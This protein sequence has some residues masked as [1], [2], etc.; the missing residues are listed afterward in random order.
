[1]MSLAAAAPKLNAQVIGNDVTFTR[2][3]TDSRNLRAGDLFVALRGERFDGHDFVGDVFA[4]GAAAAMVEQDYGARP[5]PLLVVANTRLGLGHLAQAW[6]KDLELKVVAITGSNGKTTV[7][8]M[9]AAILRAHCVQQ[10]GTAM[11]VLATE[12]NLNND[13]GVPLTLLRLSTAHRYAVIEM[14]MNHPGEI[15]Y[16]AKLAQPDAALVNNVQR[17]HLGMFANIDAV[18]DAKAEIFT[19]LRWDGVAVINADDPHA[20]LMRV[21]A[22]GMECLEFGLEKP[23]PI[24]ASFTL[25]EY[26]SRIELRT[27]RGTAQVQLPL[28]GRHNVC[29]ALAATAAATALHIEL[30]PIVAGLQAV[31][32]VKGRLVR[33]RGV[34]GSVVIDDTYNANPD[35]A[36]AALQVLAQLSGEKIFVLGDMGEVGAGGAEMHA[37]IGALARSSGINRLYALGELSRQAA[38]MFGDGAE[39]F[40]QVEQLLSALR[41]RLQAGS[42]VLVKGSRFMRMERVVEAIV[43]SEVK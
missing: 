32:S 25:M 7:K 38:A 19:G 28:P 24:S 42:N 30:P 5:G 4:A 11:Q 21:R 29:N 17:A 41:P 10:G 6:R 36:A 9:V 13:I 31:Q 8:E 40:D 26:G 22:A 18:A 27:P 16:L 35:S 34:N 2:V 14:G 37:E 39:T 3:T 33:K 23:A 20:G 1:M 43:E 15:A 12:G